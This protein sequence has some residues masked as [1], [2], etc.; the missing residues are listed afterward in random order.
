MNFHTMESVVGTL[1]IYV[2]NMRKIHSS[3]ER[4]NSKAWDNFGIRFAGTVYIMLIPPLEFFP[5]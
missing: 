1:A 3:Y 5:I 2:V 4:M